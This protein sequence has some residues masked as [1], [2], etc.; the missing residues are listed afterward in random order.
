MT[1]LGAERWLS[2]RAPGA[3]SAGRPRHLVV[4]D[5]TNSAPSPGCAGYF[6]ASGEEFLPLFQAA[7]V[8][9]FLVEAGSSACFRTSSTRLARWN[10][11]ASRTLWGTSSMSFSLRLG[12]MTSL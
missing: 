2:R 1:N 5:L 10:V 8:L 7:S 12:R 6:P 3:S 9:D 11:I 4:V